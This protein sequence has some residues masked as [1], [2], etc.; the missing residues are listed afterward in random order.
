[1]AVRLDKELNF[2]WGTGSPAEGVPAD[3]FSARWTQEIILPAGNYQ[4]FLEMDDGARVWIDG[5]LSI[6]EW[7]EP[8]G[9][10]YS[11]E[12]PLVAG[13]HRLRVEYY[14]DLGNARIRLWG[15]V[16]R[17]PSSSRP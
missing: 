10:T 8:T 13:V 11:V 4:F 9:E 17:L 6:D 14:E 3:R 2:D 16:V 1:M 12:L 7:H 15:Q 5:Q